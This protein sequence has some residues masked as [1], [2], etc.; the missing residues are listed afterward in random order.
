M[1]KSN[2]INGKEMATSLHNRVALE[3]YELKSKYGVTPGLAV[4]LIGEDPASQVYVTKKEKSIKELGMRSFNYHL[5]SSTTQKSLIDIINALNSND[6]VHG[7]LVQL[8]LP[9]TIDQHTVLSAISPEKD[10]D[11]F[12]IVN[13]GLLSQGRPNVVPCTPLGCLMMLQEVL[14]YKLDGLNAVVLG[15]SIIVGRPMAQLLLNA[16]CTVTIA[17][18][19]TK[20]LPQVCGAADI[21]VAAVGRPEMVK[22]DWIKPGATVIDVGINRVTNDLGVSKLVGDVDFKSVSPIASYISP[23]PGGVGPMT[24]ACLM[25]NT[26]V[27]A[28]RSVDSSIPADLM[29]W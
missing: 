24:I 15:R 22:G 6:K 25:L 4:I 26:C 11:G 19:K 12:H 14:G 17:H 13:S 8:P 29:P 23:V 2:I 27:S 9:A 5:P 3:V 1:I 10:V 18:S 7:I 20:N 28:L 21:L 16:N